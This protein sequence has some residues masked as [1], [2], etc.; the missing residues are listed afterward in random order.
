MWTVFSKELL[1]IVRDR[2]RFILTL[3]TTFVFLPLLLIVPY[4]YLITRTVK[5]TVDGLVLPV[6]GMQRAPALVAYLADEDIQ[7]VAVDDVEALVNSRQYAVGLII[8]GD[9]EEQIDARRSAELVLVTDKRRTMDVTYLRLK[10]VLDDY[11]ME[12]VQAR[13]EQQGLADDF[14]TPLTVE[15]KNVATVTETTGSKMG[16]LIPGM[17]IT[18][19]LSTGMPVAIAAIAGEK[20]KLT[21]EPVLFTTVNRFQLVFAKL[22]AVFAS[23]IITLLSMLIAFSIAG[24][25]IF[26]IVARNLPLD[27]IASSAAESAAAPSTS[28]L[29][30]GQYHIE[31]LAIALFLLAPFLLILLGAAL[32]ILISTW[33]RNDEEATTYLMP[34]S[35]FS[36]F[37]AFL[38]FFLEDITPHLWHY[39]VPIMGTILSMRDLLSN[40][41]D[42]A[43]LAVM[44]G[45]SG[46]CALLM[47]VLAVWMFHREEVVFRT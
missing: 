4:S 15:E 32:Q 27:K 30:V 46:L 29:P 13:L 17:I 16:L 35:I 7:S 10:A 45:T 44:F 36:T 12:L 9:Y 31:P 11:G 18:F 23:T 24:A 39:G 3:L 1:D 26:L 20:K 6:Q 41:V 38:A 5:Q 34:I 2:R 8:P 28:S 14:A 19:G 37:A 22:M 40:K 21:L 43:S 42:P 33:A 47:I 25:G